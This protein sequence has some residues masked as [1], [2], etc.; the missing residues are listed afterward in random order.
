MEG[1]RFYSKE[2][3]TH[4]RKSGVLALGRK[5][6]GYPFKAIG[7]LAA[8]ILIRGISRKLGLILQKIAKP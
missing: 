2:E 6:K 7:F 8:S 4:F 5:N 3:G 1:L